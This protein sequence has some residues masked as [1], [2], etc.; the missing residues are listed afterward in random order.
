MIGIVSA[1]ITAAALM[2][3]DG[4]KELGFYCN[5]AVQ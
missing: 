1:A 3:K 5:E 2:T 4:L